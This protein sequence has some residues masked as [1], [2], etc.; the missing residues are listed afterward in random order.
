MIMDWGK[1]K[2][3][4]KY[5][6]IEDIEHQRKI[7]ENDGIRENEGD[8][9]PM[10]KTRSKKGSEEKWGDCSNVS[11][12]SVK[13]GIEVSLGYCANG[14]MWVSSPM[15]KTRSK[16]GIEEIWGDCSNVSNTIVKRGIEG[17]LEYCANGPI[18]VISPMSKT[19]SKQGIEDKW[20]VT[21]MCL[22]PLWGKVLMEVWD[23]APMGQWILGSQILKEGW[24]R[25][26]KN[27]R[28]MKYKSAIQQGGY[29]QKKSIRIVAPHHPKVNVGVVLIHQYCQ[30]IIRWREQQLICCV[31]RIETNATNIRR[32]RDNK[33]I[34]LLMKENL[35]CQL[36]CHHLKSI[37][38]TCARRVWQFITQ[39]MKP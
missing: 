7:R 20:G 15:Y 14:P 30:Q 25:M 13:Q 36:S 27:G 8:I 34:D 2:K 19:R 29:T 4:K 33:H 18:G 24:L 32:S 23:I 37:E 26:H 38:I 28:H 35:S 3:L 11:K 22:R 31:K 12:K 9:S 16:K 1:G 5:F 10:S 39:I 6:V 21:T 17:S